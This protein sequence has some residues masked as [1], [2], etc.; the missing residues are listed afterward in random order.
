[1]ILKNSFFLIN[2]SLTVVFFSGCKDRS[3]ENLNIKKDR[4][5]HIELD[6]VLTYDLEGLSTEG[7]S[8][9]VEYKAGQIFFAK[10]TIFSNSGK[11]ELLM[12][13]TKDS[14]RIDENIYRYKISIS[15]VASESDMS[16]ESR[17]SYW[18]NYSGEIIG[19]GK[20][21][22]IDIFKDFKEQIPFSLTK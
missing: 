19:G 16:L 20:N 3:V 12:S 7:A 8:A 9:S 14:I 18:I 22:E 11:G 6:T 13:F 21:R 10:T 1:M 2:L 15:D 5:E 4:I 17:I